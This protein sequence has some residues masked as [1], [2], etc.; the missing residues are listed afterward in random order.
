V[1]L[2][3]RPDPDGIST[4]VFPAEWGTPPL[5]GRA[6]RAWILAN[7]REGEQRRLEGERV[8]WLAPERR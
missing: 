1:T 2:E 5:G 3:R 6:L 4:G 8:E 7:V